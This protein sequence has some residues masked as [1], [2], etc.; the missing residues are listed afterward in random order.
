MIYAQEKRKPANRFPSETYYGVAQVPD[1]SVDVFAEGTC[2]ILPRFGG[3]ADMP[4]VLSRSNLVEFGVEE[5]SP[6]TVPVNPHGLPRR[7]SCGSFRAEDRW[8]ERFRNCCFA[9]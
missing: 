5:M 2:A 7:L 1:R 8:R 4:R 6:L 3:L 9:L